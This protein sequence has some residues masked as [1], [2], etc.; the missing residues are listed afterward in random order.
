MTSAD[1]ARELYF[2]C[3]RMTTSEFAPLDLRARHD[4]GKGT[5][6]ALSRCGSF[7]TAATNR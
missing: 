1:R 4:R 7:A 6:A 2:E 5:F 3:S